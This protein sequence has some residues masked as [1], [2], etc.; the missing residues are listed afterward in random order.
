MGMGRHGDA[1]RSPGGAGSARRLGI[2]AGCRAPRRLGKDFLSDLASSLSG[3]LEVGS[4]ETEGIAAP[5]K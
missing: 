4:V 5:G 3:F 2:G 1:E